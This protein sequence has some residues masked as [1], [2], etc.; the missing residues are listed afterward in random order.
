MSINITGEIVVFKNK[1]GNGYHTTT[2][3]KKEDGTFDRNYI[4]VGFRKDAEVPDSA[5]LNVTNGFLTH[6][7]GQ[8]TTVCPHCEEEGVEE[9]KIPKIMVLDFEIIQTYGNNAQ[10]N[11]D[12]EGMSDVMFGNSDDLPF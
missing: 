10:I 5:K 1:S 11:P 8:K 2:S 7:L 9:T 6:Y 12:S 4:Q 3:N